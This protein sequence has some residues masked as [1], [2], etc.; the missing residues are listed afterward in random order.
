MNISLAKTE[1]HYVYVRMLP[2]FQQPVFSLALYHQAAT[3]FCFSYYRSSFDVDLFVHAYIFIS[4]L[5]F[6]L[7]GKPM[8]RNWVAKQVSKRFHHFLTHSP[9]SL[10]ISKF[11]LPNMKE[12]K[13]ENSCNN[14]SL[15]LL[16]HSP[17]H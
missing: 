7:R 15:P 3:L 9:S 16:L 13:V 6:H 4:C 10:Y 8:C 1:G 12:K 17:C 11:L 14:H 2:L 5:H